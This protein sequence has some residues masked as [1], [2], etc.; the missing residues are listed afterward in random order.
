MSDMSVYREVFSGRN[1]FRGETLKVT[2]CSDVKT[3]WKFQ[4]PIRMASKSGKQKHHH[5][6]QSSNLRITPCY[7][8]LPE[9]NI[10]PARRPKPKRKLILR[11]QCLRCEN[12][13][14]REGKHP[15]VTWD[16][17]KN[18]R[19]YQGINYQP[20]LVKAGFLVA[21]NSNYILGGGFKHLLC[22]SLPGEMIQFDYIHPGRLT[23]NLRIHPWKRRNI[24][25]TII[26]RFYVNLGG[27]NIFF[28]WVGSTTNQYRLYI[29]TLALCGRPSTERLR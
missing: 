6:C 19:F 26:F 20:Q 14:F 1:L 4:E 27:C 5:N 11:P 12:V 10:A 22:S 15:Q 8:T 23:W 24:F 17:H 2:D 29:S 3:P 18:P 13:S 28:R 7:S 16:V 21:I 9:T 25:Q